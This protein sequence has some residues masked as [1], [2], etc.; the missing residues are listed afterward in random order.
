MQTGGRSTITG[1]FV[2]FSE[3]QLDHVTSLDNGGVDGPE[4]WEWMESRFNQFKGALSEAI[5]AIFQAS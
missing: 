1:E 3:S 4:N 5:S 2:P